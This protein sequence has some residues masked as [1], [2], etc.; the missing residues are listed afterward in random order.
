MRPR[1]VHLA[2][3]LFLAAFI[4]QKRTNERKVTTTKIAPRVCARWGK[5][6]W[7]E[8]SVSAGYPSPCNRCLLLI[9]LL[10]TLSSANESFLTLARGGT[11]Q[12][13]Q[14]QER[15]LKLLNL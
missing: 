3:F 6:R 10:R 5:T 2:E 14:Q 7:G 12:Q 1:S 15:L 11:Q 9:S 4:K 13:Q 8:V